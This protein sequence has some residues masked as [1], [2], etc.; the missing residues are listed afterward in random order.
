[1]LAWNKTAEMEVS[2]DSCLLYREGLYDG[3]ASLDES[4]VH[5][6]IFIWRWLCLHPTKLLKWARENVKKNLSKCAFLARIPSIL[7]V[8][9]AT[10]FSRQVYL[11]GFL[12]FAS[13]LTFHNFFCVGWLATTWDHQKKITRIVFGMIPMPF[14]LTAYRQKQEWM[15]GPSLHLMALITKAHQ[16]KQ[17]S[18][19]DSKVCGNALVMTL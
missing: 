6:H 9:S 10:F 11:L 14:N 12:L 1:M 17:L 2:Q 16:L 5:E 3:I 7:A 15:F 8:F 4:Y 13:F 19:R 18:V